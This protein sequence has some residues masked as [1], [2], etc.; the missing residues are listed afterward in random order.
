MS[1][2]LKIHQKTNCEQP[3]SSGA[4]H[5]R[6]RRALAF[7]FGVHHGAGQDPLRALYLIATKGPPKLKGKTLSPALKEFYDQTLAAEP[8]KRASATGLTSPPFF[9]LP[10]LLFKV[11]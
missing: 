6:E 10:P 7:D 5:A 4:D 3:R 1:A 11:C 8:D 9:L 2:S